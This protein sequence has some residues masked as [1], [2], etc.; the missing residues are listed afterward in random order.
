VNDIDDSELMMLIDN[1][2]CSSQRLLEEHEAHMA[3]EQNRK[4]ESQ[5]QLEK[6]SKTLIDIKSGVEHLTEKLKVLKSVCRTVYF[7]D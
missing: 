1:V 4:D 5:S 3:A 2:H 7:Y 6:T